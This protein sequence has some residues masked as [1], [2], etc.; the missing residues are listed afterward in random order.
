MSH[1]RFVHIT[2][3]EQR[4][5]HCRGPMEVMGI[6]GEVSGVQCSVTTFFPRTASVRSFFVL[7]VQQLDGGIIPP[8]RCA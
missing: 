5:L 1:F 4:V 2:D 3:R 8:E 7:K 6:Q